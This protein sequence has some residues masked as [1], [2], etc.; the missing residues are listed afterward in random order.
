MRPQSMYLVFLQI[1]HC[2]KRIRIRLIP[3]NL[4]RRAQQ[5]L[6]ENHIRQRGEIEQL[7]IDVKQLAEQDFQPVK[8]ILRLRIEPFK[9]DIDRIHFTTAAR[10]LLVLISISSNGPCRSINNNAHRR[11]PPHPDDG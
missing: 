9:V 10:V 4:D 6:R 7:R 2:Q 5:W 8:I 3:I 11:C 1:Q